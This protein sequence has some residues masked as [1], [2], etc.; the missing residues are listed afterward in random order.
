MFTTQPAKGAEIDLTQS[1]GTHVAMK[2]TNPFGILQTRLASTTAHSDDEHGSQQKRALAR[3]NAYKG[4]LGEA[5]PHASSPGLLSTR[6][7]TLSTTANIKNTEPAVTV[8]THF[9]NRGHWLL[10]IS[11]ACG[12]QPGFRSTGPKRDLLFSLPAVEST[13]HAY[14]LGFVQIGDD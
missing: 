6:I 4:G 1:M 12:E 8:K 9:L 10:K 14:R 2:G 7:S 11:V 5:G 3:R 13:A